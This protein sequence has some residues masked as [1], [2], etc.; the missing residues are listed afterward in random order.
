VG[1]VVKPHGLRGEVVVDLVTDRTERLA[2][3]AALDAGDGRRLVVRTSRPQGPG[4]RWLVSFEGVEGREGAERL[5]GTVL[6]APAL[7]HEPGVLFVHELIGAE[8]WCADGRRAG[9]VVGVEANPASDLLVLDTGALVPVRFVVAN[10]P[11]R[12]VTLDVPE[13]LLPEG[14]DEPGG[15]D[16]PRRAGGG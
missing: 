3:G 9:T 2:T 11:G 15:T 16:D 13:G 4:Q 14:T 5:R 10:E 8:A 6:R 7:A 1:Q 12:R